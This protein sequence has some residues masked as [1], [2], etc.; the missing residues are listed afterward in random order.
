MNLKNLGIVFFVLMSSSISWSQTEFDDFTTLESKGDVPLDFTTL[1]SDKVE[2]D[3]SKNKDDDLD[4]D[5]FINTRFFIDE[6]LLSGQVLF[7]EPLSD[8]VSKVAKYTLRQEKQLFKKLRFYVLKS[9]AV[10]A[11]STDQGIIIF[12]T[13]LLAQLENEA[14]LAYIIAHEVSHF[15]ESHVREG[16][17]E[18]QNYKKSRGRYKRM[19]Y[20]DAVNTLSV[21][22]KDNELEADKIGIN[23]Y[24]NTTYS[25][26]EIYGAF[27]VLLYSYLP[28]DEKVFDTTFFDTEIMK[29]P[30]SFFPDTINEITQEEDYDDKGSTHPNIKKRID[31]A[32]DIIGDKESRG[33]K[34]FQIS[35]EEFNRV[36]NLARFESVNLNLADRN[37]VDALYEIFLLRKDFPDNKFLDLSFV[38]A[39]YGLSKYKNHGRFNEV[40]TKLKK[41]EGES[42]V[43]HVFIKGLDRQQLNIITYRHLYD[44]TVKY[45]SDEIFTEYFADFKKEFSL[46]SNV[47]IDELKS[48]NFEEFKADLDSNLVSFNLQDSIRKVDESDLSKF[49]KIKLKKKLRALG[50]DDVKITGDDDFHLFAL[51]DLI[52]D[53][54]LRD[55]LRKSKIAYENEIEDEE[56]AQ[57]KRDLDAQKNG[58][59]LGIKKLVVVD[60]IYETYKLNNDRNHGKSENKKIDVSNI[61]QESY[62]KLDLQVDVLDSKTMNEHRVG[63][64]NEIGLI[65]QWMSEIVDHEDIDMLSSSHDK[66]KEVSKNHGTS[67]FMFS[68]IYGYKERSEA[69]IMH[70]Y[71]ILLVYTA[72]FALADLLVVHNYFELVAFEVD[73]ENDKVEFVEVH[74]VNL[75]GINPILRVYIYD[76][77]HQLSSEK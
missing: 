30:G 76:I 37:Y 28:F 68:G 41:I 56:K 32:I 6:L 40:T 74:D 25:V 70:L 14:Q 50:S 58:Y 33:D 63:E 24:L 2:S 15:T 64:Y 49:Q 11:F 55:D 43:L 21:H 67:K 46:N 36:K 53:K 9:T 34:K 73:A 8:Y 22:A 54:G 44:M 27:Q 17:V 48:Q 19:S 5:F 31:E 16:Y 72:P 39:M 66:M 12:T 61:Y 18:R 23:L 10:N 62:R 47:K 13:G 20:N 4:K 71:G 38:K 45:P 69:T 1:S 60:P 57:D 59:H 3:M 26:D 65:K 52:V 29:V 42:Y 7:N 77:L 75:K 35:E 51:R